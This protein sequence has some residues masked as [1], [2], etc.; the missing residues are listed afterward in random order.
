MRCGVCLATV[1]TPSAAHSTAGVGD[2]AAGACLWVLRAS[3]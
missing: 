1:V 3:R 2:F